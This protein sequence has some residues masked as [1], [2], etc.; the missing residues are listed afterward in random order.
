MHGLLPLRGRTGVGR[1]DKHGARAGRPTPPSFRVVRDTLLEY[2]ERG[3]FRGF[4]V[5]VEDPLD[6]EVDA[7]DP[8]LPPD[9][10][11]RVTFHFFWIGPGPFR[12]SLGPDGRTLSAEGILPRVADHPGV[13]E[14]LDG[15]VGERARGVPEVEAGGRPDEPVGRSQRDEGPGRAEGI[16]RDG[17]DE[18]GE[19]DGRDGR[20]ERPSGPTLPPH[21]RIDPEKARASLVPGADG[22]LDLVVSILSDHHEYAVRR[23]LNLIN[24]IW[25]RLQDRHQR[26]L[27]DVFE[28]PME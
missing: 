9:V 27:W 12:L 23:L 11:G 3:V 21:R 5:H 26:Y 8:T 1:E 7:G 15:F 2:A 20:D 16:G 13:R 28:A 25:V 6:A 17:R 18:G 10:P 24:E 22:D 19:R 4:D 14:D